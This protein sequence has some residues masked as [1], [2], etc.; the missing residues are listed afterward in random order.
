[1]SLPDSSSGYGSNGFKVPK[2]RSF[3]PDDEDYED[4]EFMVNTSLLSRPDLT[5]KMKF[6]AILEAIPVSDRRLLAHIN[7]NCPNLTEVMQSLQRIYGKTLDDVLEEIEMLPNYRQRPEREVGPGIVVTVQV[8]TIDDWKEIM[9]V[10]NVCANYFRS[11]DHDLD[12]EQTTFNKLAG[13]LPVDFTLELFSGKFGFERLASMAF[14]KMTTEREKSTLQT[15]KNHVHCHQTFPKRRMMTTNG[16]VTFTTNATRKRAQKRR[17]LGNQIDNAE[18]YNDPQTRCPV[19]NK[20]G[21]KIWMCRRG[22]GAI[23]QCAYENRI[24]Y[25]CLAA[26]FNRTHRNECKAKCGTCAGAHHTSLHLD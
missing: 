11:A 21:H 9:K 24:C 16:L 3:V 23:R 10:A 12:L 19:C 20:R 18:N 25:A 22:A 1:M 13:K 7:R 8:I 4:F 14:E 15:N 6:V 2:L 17:R 26:P 5:A